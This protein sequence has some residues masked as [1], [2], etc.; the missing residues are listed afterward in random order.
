MLH[1]RVSVDAKCPRHPLRR[2]QV[3]PAGCGVCQEL[4]AVTSCVERLERALRSAG[5]LGPDL[6]WRNVRRSAK[7]TRARGSIAAHDPIA[8]GNAPAPDLSAVPGKT[9]T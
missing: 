9:E 2:Y 5:R 7:G 4:L 6:R 8:A 1:V 3:A